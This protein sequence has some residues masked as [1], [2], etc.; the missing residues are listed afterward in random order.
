MIVKIVLSK[1][2]RFSFRNSVYIS[3][4]G[5]EETG[6]ASSPVP[7]K[8][9]LFKWSSKTILPFVLRVR[10]IVCVVILLFSQPIV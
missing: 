7:H 3:Q 10:V 5:L 1:S 4:S 2:A 9:L 8:N 6:Q